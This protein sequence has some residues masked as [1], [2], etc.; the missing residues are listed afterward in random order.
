[1]AAFDTEV[2]FETELLY[3]LGFFGKNEKTWH[4]LGL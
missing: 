4:K 2:H 3:F 1:M